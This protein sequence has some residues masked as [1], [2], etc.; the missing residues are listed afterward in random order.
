MTAP[1]KLNLCVIQWK[2]GKHTLFP[3]VIVNVIVIVIVIVIA[4]VIVTV[5]VFVIVCN[6]VEGKRV[7]FLPWRA[8]ESSGFEPIQMLPH[9]AESFFQYD[10]AI[11]QMPA[12]SQERT[13]TGNPQVLV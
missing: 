4:I 3:I 7:R 13:N 11:Q 12:F 8:P 1:V 2:A 10:V 9:S 5:I 6:S